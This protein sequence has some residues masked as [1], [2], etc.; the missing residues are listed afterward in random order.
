MQAH[1]GFVDVESKEG[2]GTTFFLYLPVPHDADLERKEIETDSSEAAGGKETILL[3]EDEAVLRNFLKG[4]FESK[5]YR[6]YT[7]ADGLEAVEV[8]KARH[9]EIDLV[10][11]DVGLPKMNGVDEFKKMR[12]ID[13]QVKI[14]LASGFIEPET[15][16]ELLRS[17]AKG[18]IQKPYKP[19]DVLKEI[20]KILDQSK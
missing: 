4:L 13:P 11:T 14:L 19:Y 17:G 15:K 1:R 10:L 5:G 7:A 9:G 3:T 18:F 16:A 8:Y 20:R 2:K 6:V 12:E